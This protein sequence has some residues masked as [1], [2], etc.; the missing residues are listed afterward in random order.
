MISEL[1]N[2]IIY[3][4]NIPVDMKDSFII[5]CYKRKGNATD[6]GPKAPRTCDESFIERVLENLI[7]SQVDINNM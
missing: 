7:C 6:R 4:E 5:N 2:Q 3:E 1:A